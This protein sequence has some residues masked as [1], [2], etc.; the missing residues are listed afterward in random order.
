MSPVAPLRPCPHPGCPALVKGG[1]CDVH[2]GPYPEHRWSTDRRQDV[3]RLRGRANQERRTRLFMRESLCRACV[4]QGRVAAATVADHVIPLA[5]GGRDNEANLQPLCRF[6]SDAKTQ[7]EAIR[8][9]GRR[10]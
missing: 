1:R 5:E 10:R 3:H 6:C 8:G 7:A 2:G 9:K 4:Q